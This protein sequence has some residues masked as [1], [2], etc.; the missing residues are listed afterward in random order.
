TTRVA[1]GAVRSERFLFVLMAAGRS[2]KVND[3]GI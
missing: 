3:F 1:N 2:P